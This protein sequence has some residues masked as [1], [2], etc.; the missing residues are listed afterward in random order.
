M[1]FYI[2]L[3]F[4][5]MSISLVL[6]CISGFNKLSGDDFAESNNA[7][8]LKEDSHPS[9]SEGE[10]QPSQQEESAVDDYYKVFG[11]KRIPMNIPKDIVIERINDGLEKLITD[12]PKM[13]PDEEVLSIEVAYKRIVGGVIFLGGIFPEWGADHGDYFVFSGQ[14]NV[15]KELAFKYGYA[16]KKEDGRIYRWWFSQEDLDEL[17]AVDEDGR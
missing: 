6:Y 13:L 5:I 4:V 15:R 10:S 9:L 12:R 1:N 14:S 7:V 8:P 3:I 17:K 16:V 11:P 2:R